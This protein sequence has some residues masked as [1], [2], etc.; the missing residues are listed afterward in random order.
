[1]FSFLSGVYVYVIAWTLLER[2]S[3]NSL[4][5]KNLSDSVV[6]N[7]ISVQLFKQVF[8]WKSAKT[9]KLISTR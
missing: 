8:H 2:D 4:G 9:S 7:L 1:M 6:S 3:A 5:P